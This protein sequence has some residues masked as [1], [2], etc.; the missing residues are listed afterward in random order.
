MHCQYT[1]ETRILIY[2]R[3]YYLDMVY[4]MYIDPAVRV[5]FFPDR[6]VRK[7]IAKFLVRCVNHE[8]G[9][10]WRGLVSKLQR[11]LESCEHSRVQCEHCR[12]WIPPAEQN[13]H[14]ESC[15]M[16]QVPCPFADVG[17]KQTDKVGLD[18]VQE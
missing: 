13:V 11:H 6:F 2:A 5:Q 14:F 16:V 1:R 4:S 18:E 17:C 7:E 8:K 15:P 3:V 9:C 10:G 12:N